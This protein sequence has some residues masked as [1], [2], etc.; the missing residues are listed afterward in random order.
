MMIADVCLHFAKEKSQ[1]ISYRQIALLPIF[2]L[3]DYVTKIQ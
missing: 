3:M 1:L 2:E